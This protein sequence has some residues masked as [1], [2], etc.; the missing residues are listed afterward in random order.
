MNP[1]N[2]YIYQLF[3]KQIIV[4]RPSSLYIH[5]YPSLHYAETI[6]YNNLKT[7]IYDLMTRLYD[8][9]HQIWT[10]RIKICHE[11]NKSKYDQ[12][13]K[14]MRAMKYKYD[15]LI[16]VIRSVMKTMKY[17]YD[18]LKKVIRSFSHVDNKCKSSLYCIL[19]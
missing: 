6:T 12:L 2:T 16:K 14:V 5:Y 10:W 7:W 17:K 13:M 3:I 18:L 1:N 11:D 4:Y 15:L 8:Q 19:L 9:C